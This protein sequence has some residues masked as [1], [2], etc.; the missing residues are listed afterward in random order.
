MRT[1]WLRPAAIL[2]S[3]LGMISAG[4]GAPPADEVES[5]VSGAG[6]A[7]PDKAPAMIKNTGTIEEVSRQCYLDG[8]T[9]LHQ[10]CRCSNTGWSGFCGVGLVHPGC[11]YCI[12]D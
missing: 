9:N 2:F 8:C 10:A 4:C 6:A 7:L 12:C 5:G 1:K 3:L 11:V